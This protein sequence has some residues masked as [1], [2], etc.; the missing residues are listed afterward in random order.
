MYLIYS[1]VLGTDFGGACLSRLR[2]FL[3]LFDLDFLDYYVYVL[4]YYVKIM[5]MYHVCCI[6]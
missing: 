2:I 5:Y 3:R 6:K 4:Q 1:F